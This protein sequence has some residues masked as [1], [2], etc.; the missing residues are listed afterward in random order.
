MDCDAVE[1]GWCEGT[2]DDDSE[3][4]GSD[5]FGESQNA[6][7]ADGTAVNL[8]ASTFDKKVTDA[9]PQGD[10]LLKDN[11]IEGSRLGEFDGD[12]GLWTVGGPV[13]VV[14]GV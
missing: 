13:G 7:V 1:D 12:G 11:D 2:V 6:F 10:I 14:C 8:H 4:V 3:A 5:R 9:L